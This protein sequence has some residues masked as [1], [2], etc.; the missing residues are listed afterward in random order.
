MSLIKKQNIDYT[1][2]ILFTK[3]LL[4]EG[5]S[6]QINV[7]GNSMYPY[8]RNGNTVLIK[9]SPFITLRTGNVIVFR[10][11][12]RL[13]LHRIIAIRKNKSQHKL[14]TKGDSLFFYDNPITEDL[15]FGKIIEIK[16]NNKTYKIDTAFHLFLNKLII[17]ISILNLPFFI[18][19][20]PLSLFSHFLK[21]HLI[22]NPK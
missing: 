21:S 22:L 19:L 3:E 13:I 6:V 5:Y 17:P 12:N 14:I 15:Y 4:D 1:N 9:K 16:R 11:V 7:G 20:I 10:S 18:I 2:I 8:L